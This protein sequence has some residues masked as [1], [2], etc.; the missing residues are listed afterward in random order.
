VK[1][2]NLVIRSRRSPNNLAGAGG[3]RLTLDEAMKTLGLRDSE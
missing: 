1:L 3:I 2:W